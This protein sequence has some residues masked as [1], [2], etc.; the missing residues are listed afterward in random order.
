MCKVISRIYLP[1]LVCA[2]MRSVKH[3]VGS[4]VPHLRVAV[5]QVLFHAQERFLGPVLAKLHVLEFSQRFRDG[6]RTVHTRL[7]T[8]SAFLASIRL[9]LFLCETIKTGLADRSH[10]T[11][12][13]TVAHICLITFDK[14][15]RQLIKLIEIIARIRDL[16]R[17]VPQPP[18][19]LQNTFEIPRL[20]CFR[21]RVVVS[22]ITAPAMVSRIPKVDE[23]RF[24][25]ADVQEAVR[26][27]WETGL[28][29]ATGGS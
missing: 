23:D 6:S 25:V 27:G 5:F 4:Q 19:H 1:L 3:S 8:S 29:L 28:N 2:V 10:R 13:S 17:L 18:H 14:L 22:Q 12:T 21:V 15:H 16:P 20:L 9:D 26:F 11:R 7:G 24:G